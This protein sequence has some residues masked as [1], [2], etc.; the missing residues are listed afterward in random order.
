MQMDNISSSIDT[1][2]EKVCKEIQT[3]DMSCTNY[4]D[5]IFALADL[6]EA[7]TKIVGAF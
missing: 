3:T 2:I 7:R 4:A 6:V 5:T 1:T